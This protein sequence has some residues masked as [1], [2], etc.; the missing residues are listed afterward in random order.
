M[1]YKLKTNFS[2]LNHLDEEQKDAVINSR[3]SS[4]IIAG[5]GSGKTMVITYKIA[6]LLN[7]GISASSILLLT[8]TKASALEMIKRARIVSNNDLHGMTFGTFHH[9][10]YI[11][12]KKYSHLLKI[13]DNFTVMD[14]SDSKELIKKCRKEIL[15]RYS[16]NS[17]L[18][19]AATIQKIISYASDTLNTIEATISTKYSNYIPYTEEINNIYIKYTEEKE[20]TNSLDYNDLLT[21]T[22]Y[23]L[24]Y[25][26]SVRLKESQRY[27]WI[28]I[29]EFQD[30]NIVQYRIVELLSQIHGNLV[31]VGDD[32]Q[33]IYSF[34][35]A[36]V[37]NI[38]KLFVNK[39]TK[40]FKIQNNYRSTD[41][42][43]R[44]IN[45][46]IPKQSIPK[47]LQSN[48]K[49]KTKPIIVN[50]QNNIYQAKFV[51]QRIKEL[52]NMG[53]RYSDMAVLYRSHYHSLELQMELQTNS[54]PYMILSGLKFNE[55]AHIKDIL[56]F[57]KIQ[58]NPYD[59][60]S[61]NRVLKLFDGIGNVS[62][63]KI[64][65]ILNRNE[66]KLEESMKIL[67]NKKLKDTLKNIKNLTDNKETP[68]DF[69]QNICNYFYFEYLEDK[70]MNFNDRIM[71]IRR[72]IEIASDY[73][74]LE[75]FLND[76]LL[77][78]NVND[79][80]SKEKLTLST[81]HQAKGLEWKVVFVISV[82]SGEFPSSYAIINENI[83]E[84]ERIFYVA[85]TRAKDELYII[86]TSTKVKNAFY[87]GKDYDFIERLP[88]DIYE[89]WEVEV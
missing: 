10:G 3:D 44:F 13:K 69:I 70:Y 34:R 57:L 85:I 62:S 75:D 77:D 42:I 36:N 88:K 20:R 72:L 37:E 43:V 52:H 56:A 65:Q 50:T 53:I 5:P 74:N 33:S 35:G 11:I 68:K 87:L 14:S 41:K 63:N 82:A 39:K 86:R 83:D 38:K 76:L 1:K 78:E 67:T 26:E 54:I 2:F 45:K 66:Y 4:L 55:T 89:E 84:E 58:L 60:I 30:T 59:E 49:G 61:W 79:N 24:E 19:N 28:L 22:L 6:Y 9:F 16:K 18:P 23:I 12:L 46:N 21:K 27:E 31:M 51:A 48:R 64:I 81:V 71:D 47:I 32:A 7:M 8:F 17:K 40:I 80:G 25:Y 15:K 73:E 29:D